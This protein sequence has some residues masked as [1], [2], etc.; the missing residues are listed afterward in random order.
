MLR[1]FLGGP[2][3]FADARTLLEEADLPAGETTIVHKLIA[4]R[5]T[6]PPAAEHRFV[7]VE[8]L[9]TDLTV[10]W[11]DPQQHGC[12]LTGSFSNT[13]GTGV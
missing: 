3:G 11:F 7:A 2:A 6:R 9:L 12:P 13:H 8:A 5:A 10:P 4:H 1:L